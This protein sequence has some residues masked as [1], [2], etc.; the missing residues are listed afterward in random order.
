MTPKTKKVK[1]VL[2]DIDGAES[3]SKD[4]VK[5]IKHSVKTKLGDVEIILCGQMA[6][7]LPLVLCALH[8]IL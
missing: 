8:D 1:C 7:S 2:L 4:V 3:K 6:V 5:A